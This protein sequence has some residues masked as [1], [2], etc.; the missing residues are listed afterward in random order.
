[1]TAAAWSFSAWIC[2]ARAFSS[3]IFWAVRSSEIFAESSTTI[4]SP[5]FTWEPSATSSM[6]VEPP[7]TSQRMSTFSSLD[8][9]A[10]SVTEIV[11]SCRATVW[12]G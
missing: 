12:E 6:I 8:S 2:A 9:V 4:V 11:R 5:T 10:V 3:A 1:M 7:L